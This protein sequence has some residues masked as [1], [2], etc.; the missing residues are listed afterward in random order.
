[1]FCIFHEKS[2]KYRY[3]YMVNHKEREKERDFMTA[4]RTIIDEFDIHELDMPDSFKQAVKPVVEYLLDT[5]AS[6]SVAIRLAALMLESYKGELKV[7]ESF[8]SLHPENRIEIYSS[9]DVYLAFFFLMLAAKADNLY[10]AREEKQ[11]AK[12]ELSCVGDHETCSL[13]QEKKEQ[14]LSSCTYETVPPFHV[15]CRCGMIFKE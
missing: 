2:A 13:C 12:Y 14:L 11:C 4:Y 6:F 9:P 7:S 10:N 1:M 3:F 15:G 5:H 8:A